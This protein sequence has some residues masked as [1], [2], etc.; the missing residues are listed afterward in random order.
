VA[1]V[2]SAVLGG[3]YPVWPMVTLLGVAAKTESGGIKRLA[4][5][6]KKTRRKYLKNIV[7]S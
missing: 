3:G 5:K 7:A 4:A 2:I 1:G 6:M